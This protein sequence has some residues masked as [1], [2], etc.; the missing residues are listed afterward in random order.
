[1]QCSV[2]VEVLPVRVSVCVC[3]CVCVCVLCVVCVCCVFQH[4]KYTH[5]ID[6]MFWRGSSA[7]TSCTTES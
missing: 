5:P 7:S 1:M 6:A 4:E 3:V 2:E